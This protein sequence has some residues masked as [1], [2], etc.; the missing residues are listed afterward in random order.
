[1]ACE[2]RS[3][4]ARGSDVAR[5]ETHVEPHVM[6]LPGAGRNL[7]LAVGR[8]DD[9]AALV[10][11]GREGVGIENLANALDEDWRMRDGESQQRAPSTRDFGSARATHHSW[12]STDWYSAPRD[13]L[14]SSRAS[15]CTGAPRRS[16][17]AASPRC[18][19]QWHASCTCAGTRQSSFA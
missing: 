17:C 1:M 10:Q 11:A 15:W 8:L 14:N 12:R 7:H 16:A 3:A 4:Y 13:P 9:D 5:S 6:A 18:P 2:G 19:C